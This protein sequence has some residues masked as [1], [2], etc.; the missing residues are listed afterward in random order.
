MTPGT[1]DT[2][3]TQF[4]SIKSRTVGLTEDERKELQHQASLPQEVHTTGGLI[5]VERPPMTVD[6]WREYAAKRNAESQVRAAE[7]R[8]KLE[9]VP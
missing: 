5:I 7:E 8:D 6:A 1:R 2:K 4:L 3:R 9:D